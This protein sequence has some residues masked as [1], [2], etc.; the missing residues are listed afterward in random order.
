MRN[1]LHK[2]RKVEFLQ[3]KLDNS[4]A[5][6]TDLKL[7]SGTCKQKLYRLEANNVINLPNLINE[8]LI[9]CMRS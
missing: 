2:N 3:N 9:D 8:D 6:F 7:K 1:I 5:K 4:N